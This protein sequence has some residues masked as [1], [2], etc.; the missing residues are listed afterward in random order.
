[1]NADSPSTGSGRGSRAALAEVIDRLP[2]VDDHV[3]GALREDPT[4]TADLA[5]HIA[6]TDR[7]APPG[8]TW[9]DTLLGVSLR[10]W[11]A[12]LLDIAP[13]ADPDSYFA[14]RVELGA[15]EVT[16]RMLHASGITHYLLDTGYRGEEIHG[17]DGMRRASGAAVDE[18]VR[19]ESIAEEVAL[20]GTSAEGFADAFTQRLHERTVQAVGT[21]SVAA[22]RYGLDFDPARPTDREVAAAAGAWLRRDGTA[23]R[24]RVDDPVLLRFLVWTALDRGLPLQFHTGLG[25][26]DLHLTRSDPACLTDLIKA[27]EPAKTEIVLLHCYPFHRNAAY[28]SRMFTYVSM[29]VGEALNYV[30]ARAPAVVAET[31]EVV[32][33]HKLMFSSD[34]WGP[35]ELHYLGALQ[36]RRSMTRVLSGLVDDDELTVHQALSLAGQVAD[37]T[38]RRVYRLPDPA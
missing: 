16:R 9:F 21:K 28:L 26:P 13:D 27:A 36:W 22:Y 25:D 5:R 38:A 3:H 29:D 6:E 31:L 37:R 4:D 24:W 19:L 10:R 23:G 35:A 34:A 18:V 7:P 20:A 32:P 8:T 17:V 33:F 1:V 15:A 30:G 12:P 2:L 14:R 11:C